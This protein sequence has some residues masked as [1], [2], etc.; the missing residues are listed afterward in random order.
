MIQAKTSTAGDMGKEHGCWAHHST[1]LLVQQ[2]IW[3]G[4]FCLSCVSVFL[5]PMGVAIH[6][7][8]WWQGA[9]RE[10]ARKEI[11]ARQKHHGSAWRKIL[12]ILMALTSCVE[13]K[14]LLLLQFSLA[15]ATSLLLLSC[16]TR[17]DN[18]S[19]RHR[20]SSAGKS[21]RGN[22]IMIHQKQK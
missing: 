2:I 9:D 19:A 15:S 3:Y 7:A 16:I 18:S 13:Y 5:A 17:L 20:A 22:D 8:N 4:V 21:G 6:H 12:P 10:K 11:E 1:T 14:A